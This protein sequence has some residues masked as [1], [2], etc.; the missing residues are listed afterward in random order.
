MQLRLT[1]S[2]MTELE[3]KRSGLHNSKHVLCSRF[4][5]SVHLVE[6]LLCALKTRKQTLNFLLTARNFV[7]SRECDIKAYN[8]V[9]FV[10]DL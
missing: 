6:H 1:K 3:N 10:A 2:L 7:T 5:F 4:F 9:V 8:L